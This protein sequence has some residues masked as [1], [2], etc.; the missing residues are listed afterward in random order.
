[1]DLVHSRQHCSSSMTGM[2]ACGNELHLQRNA[3]TGVELLYFRDSAA[4]FSPLNIAS[5]IVG[6]TLEYMVLPIATWTSKYEKQSTS[7]IETGLPGN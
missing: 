7:T 5:R 3:G 2:A 1:M 4:A 6:Q